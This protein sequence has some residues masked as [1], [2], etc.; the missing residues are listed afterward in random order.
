MVS[1]LLAGVILI[2]TLAAPWIERA[3]LLPDNPVCPSRRLAGIDCPGCGMTRS[4]VALGRGELGLALTLN[5]IAPTLFA[6]ALIHAGARGAKLVD[7]SVRLHG[8]DLATIVTVIV[9]YLARSVQIW[10]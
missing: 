7:P 3:G 4:V 6:I 8:L 1:L 10:S 2:G 5:W 9:V